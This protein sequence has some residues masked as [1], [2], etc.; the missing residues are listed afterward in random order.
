MSIVQLLSGYCPTF[1][2]FSGFS[3]FSGFCVLMGICL[4]CPGVVRV[5]SGFS[6]SIVWVLSGFSMSI[7]W[8]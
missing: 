7:V 6:M 5:L 8:F 2:G 1:C 3:G 4:C